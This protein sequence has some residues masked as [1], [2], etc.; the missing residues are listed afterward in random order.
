MATYFLDCGCAV[1]R[2]KDRYI[3]RKCGKSLCPSHAYQYVDE[4]NASITKY[5]PLYCETCYKSVYKTNRTDVLV[6]CG[7]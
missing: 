6:E 2:K 1:K 7:A 5:S 4:S 3:C